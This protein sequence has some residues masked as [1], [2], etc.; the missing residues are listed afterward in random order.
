[1]KKI[2]ASI[3]I[4]ICACSSLVS[5]NSLVTGSTRE[6]RQYAKALN[7]AIDAENFNTVK[8][9]IEECPES[10]NTYPT[11]APSWWQGEMLMTTIYYPLSEACKVGNLE[12]V[13]LLVEN[14]ADVN[15]K[16]PDWELITPIHTTLLYCNGDWYDIIM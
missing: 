13:K 7:N 8:Q 11:L 2:I 9:I 15:S 4:L 6:E 3:L 14:G 5:C 16:N 12:M 1:M 10:V